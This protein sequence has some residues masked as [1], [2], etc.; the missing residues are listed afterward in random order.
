MQ[1]YKDPERGVMNLW[2]LLKLQQKEGWNVW[3]GAMTGSSCAVYRESDGG[4]DRKSATSHAIVVT[5]S[6]TSFH[7]LTRTTNWLP[8]CH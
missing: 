3:A 2:L 6:L 5:A 1:A 7:I 8:D 4:G